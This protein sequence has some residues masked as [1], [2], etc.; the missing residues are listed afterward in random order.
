[1][2]RFS[3]KF[4]LAVVLALLV[5][6]LIVIWIS[7]SH[8][9]PLD[10]AELPALEEAAI[11]PCSEGWLTRSIVGASW[12][13][14]FVRYQWYDYLIAQV[15]FTEGPTFKEIWV[16][17][18]GDGAMDTRFDSATAVAAKYPVPCDLVNAVAPAIRKRIEEGFDGKRQGEGGTGERSKT[19]SAL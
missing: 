10:T 16:D 13:H 18:T 6:V 12:D 8:S 3:W 14:F 9:T 15:E 2:P 17:T 4:D 19:K 1:M 7:A 5:W 11:Q